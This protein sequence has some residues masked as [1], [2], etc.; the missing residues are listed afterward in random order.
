MAFGKDREELK[1]VRSLREAGNISRNKRPRGGGGGG[2][3]LRFKDQLKPSTV[4]EDT[5][6]FIPG[7]YPFVEVLENGDT[8]ETLLPYYCFTEHFDGKHYTSSICSAGVFADDKDKR[9]PCLGCEIFWDTGGKKGGR[10]SRRDM[11]AF[12]VFNLGTFHEV[13]EVDARGNV[14]ISDKTKKPFMEWVKCAGRRCDACAAGKPTT[15]G[16]LQH[17]D[18]GY[19]HFSQ[20][21]EYAK[22]IGRCCKNCGGKDT[23]QEVAYLCPNCKEAVI[24]MATTHLKDEEII[25]LVDED[26]Q[27]PHCRQKVLLEEIVECKDCGNPERAGIFDVDISFKKVAGPAGTNQSTLMFTGFG[28]VCPI[29]PVYDVKPMDFTKMYEPTPLQVQADKFKATMPVQTPRQPVPASEISKPYGQ[30]KS[31]GGGGMFNR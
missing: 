23:I 31:G 24:D 8:Q 12:T 14:K 20:L 5:V 30:E 17:Y 16:R 29:D 15:K 19:G 2:G 22:T 4:E 9:D 27:C 6:R 13:E 18:V 3:W 21:K 11:K 10:M 26:M 7:E 1:K 25:K 28:P